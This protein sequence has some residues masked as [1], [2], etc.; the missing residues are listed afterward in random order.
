[1][2]ANGLLKSTYCLPQGMGAAVSSQRLSVL[3]LTGL[4]HLCLE[5]QG[6]VSISFQVVSWRPSPVLA[7]GFPGRLMAHRQER[8]P[9]V[10]CAPD[11]AM[12][13]CQG[14]FCHCVAPGAPCWNFCFLDRA[15]RAIAG[16]QGRVCTCAQ[17]CGS[18]GISGGAW[19]A[20]SCL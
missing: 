19:A 11:R 18:L 9:L 16:S 8:T 12:Q 4:G 3:G 10:L 1:M 15:S 2:L 17:L 20:L 5:K 14:R 6:F 13:G 7:R